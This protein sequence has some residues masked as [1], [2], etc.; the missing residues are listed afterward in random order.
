MNISVCPFKGET[1]VN[2]SVGL[3]GHAAVDWRRR[4][5]PPRGFTPSR[6]K[7]NICLYGNPRG[8]GLKRGL[9]PAG[10]MDVPCV[11]TVWNSDLFDSTRRGGN[12]PRDVNVLIYI[13]PWGLDL[14]GPLVPGHGLF[15][16]EL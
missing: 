7:I 4:L 1:L 11:T 3:L 6:C 8:G 2:I 13:L 15:M 9:V 10:H 12:P 16:Y 14:G 5:P